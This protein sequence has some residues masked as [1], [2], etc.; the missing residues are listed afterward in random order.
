MK[1][2]MTAKSIRMDIRHGMIANE[3]ATKYGFLS[4]EDLFEA[5]RN[6]YGNANEVIRTLK[7][8]E[9]QREKSKH[10]KLKKMA[11]ISSEIQQTPSFLELQIHEVPAFNVHSTPFSEPEL[12]ELE[13][14]K[15]DEK[16]FSDLC[17]G[18][19]VTHK[20]LVTE[21]HQ[22]V[23]NLIDVR[24][25]LRNLL[26]LISENQQLVTSLKERHEAVSEKILNKTQELA[27]MREILEE[28][29]VKI[30]ELEKVTIYVLPTSLNVENYGHPIPEFAPEEIMPILNKLTQF[31]QA[32]EL[33]LSEVKNIAKLSLLL[34]FFQNLQFSVNLLFENPMA[35]L[36]YHDF[37]NAMISEEA[38]TEAP[39]DEA[40]EATP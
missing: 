13:Q 24:K 30:T 16:E 19:E 11:A 8:N 35:E 10:Q 9:K 40:V 5:L 12:S 22:I 2:T 28:I 33:K 15:K 39:A 6:G 27:E 38:I 20:Q 23:D 26:Q 14:L 7:S 17:I 32:D 29:R 34:K 25:V 36:L 31:A 37:V 4:V 1:Q 3:M 18:L 21:R